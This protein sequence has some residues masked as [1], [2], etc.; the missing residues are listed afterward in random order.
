MRELKT[1]YRD[2]SAM[3]P[4]SV[5][6]GITPLC[7]P[8][9]QPEDDFAAEVGG[10]YSERVYSLWQRLT[11]FFLEETSCPRKRSR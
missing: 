5:C 10:R 1:Q 3:A 2:I 8:I 11:L 7:A 4:I 9:P 6:R